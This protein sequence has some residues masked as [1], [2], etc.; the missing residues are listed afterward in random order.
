[1]TD[2]AGKAGRVYF[3]GAGPGDAGLLTRRGAE[4]LGRC[5]VVLHAARVHASVLELG[6]AERI[7]LGEKAHEDPRAVAAKLV[8]LAGQGRI[9][10]RLAAGDP[11]LFASG[12]EE[13]AYV[14]KHG[15]PFEVVPGIVG[16]VA[17]GA[18]AGLLLSRRSDAS[19][20]VALVD[21][22][23]GLSVHE[24]GKVADATD[25]ISVHLAKEDVDELTR[26]LVFHGRSPDDPAA[27]LVD[28]ARPSQRVV[29]GP[30]EDIARLA[31]G[32]EAS[33]VRLLV[34]EVVARR[35][36]LRWFD[37]RPLWG[38]RVLVTRAREQASAAAA[39][40]VERGAEPVVV[41]TIEL[42]PPRDPA[43]VAA[44]IARA[45]EGQYAWVVFTSAN[46]VQRSWDA[47]AAA[48]KDARVFGA[49]RLAAIGPATAQ[50]LAE[51]GLRADVMARELKGEGLAEEMLRALGGQ[52]ALRSR[53][54]VLR[55]E[56]AR[57]VLPDTLRAAGCVVDVVGV[58][59]TRPVPDAAER[60]REAVG[61]GR[62]DAVTFSSSSTVD[63]LC[64]ALGEDA[65][66]LLAP[67]RVVSIGPITTKTAEKRGLR[68]D[69]TAA[70][71][72]LPGLV[73]ALVASFEAA[74]R[75]GA[76]SPPEEPNK[77]D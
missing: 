14:S 44:A 50:A 2:S 53:V 19:P 62:L 15:I 52:E 54:L 21:A 76:R 77:L 35:E 23:E 51:H 6:P 22:R 17:A 10:G 12:D 32:L 59:E 3:I 41:P 45:A 4:L 25:V 40:L 28:V 57:E 9:V 61:K 39:L 71:Y 38:K 47:I 27:V 33:T 58:Y 67:L 46:G 64:D 20:S 63:N 73:D 18:Y 56:E 69:A 72:T 55:A 66:R 5:D 16:S 70:E 31:S 75:G 1:M 36:P 60:L 26:T 74:V 49:S 37:R 48:S 8:L 7:A 29:T 24:W 13:V 43:A 65:P 68:V 42:H 11:Y 34:G 30:L